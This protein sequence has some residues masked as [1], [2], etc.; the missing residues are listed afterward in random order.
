MIPIPNSSTVAH[1]PRLHRRR[2]S[3]ASTTGENT[4]MLKVETKI[5]SKTSAIETRAHAIATTAT[6]SRIVRT[7]IETSTSGRLPSPADEEDCGLATRS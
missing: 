6:T 3:I 1:N 4:A 2:C 7:E 5:T